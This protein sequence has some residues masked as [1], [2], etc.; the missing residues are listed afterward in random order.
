MPPA[1]PQPRSRMKE[2]WERRAIWVVW[3]HSWIPT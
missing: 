2:A 1:D 3:A